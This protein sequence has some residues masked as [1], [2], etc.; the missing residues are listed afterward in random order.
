MPLRSTTED[1][2]ALM[3][4]EEQAALTTSARVLKDVDGALQHMTVK[5]VSI[6]PLS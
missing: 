2:N 4:M 1:A 3:G 6:M 5:S